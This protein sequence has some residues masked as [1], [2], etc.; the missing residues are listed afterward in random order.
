[1][2]NVCVLMNKSSRGREIVCVCEDLFVILHDTKKE[3]KTEQ[4]TLNHF[5]PFA[6]VCFG[7]IRLFLCKVGA[8]TWRAMTCFSRYLH[9]SLAVDAFSLIRFSFFLLELE[10]L[11]VLFVAIFTRL[12]FFRLKGEKAKFKDRKSIGDKCGKHSVNFSAHHFISVESG[13]FLPSIHHRICAIVPFDHLIVGKASNVFPQPNVLN[14]KSSFEIQTIIYAHSITIK[15]FIR[16]LNEFKWTFVGIQSPET[17][18]RMKN[19]LWNIERFVEHPI[20]WSIT[21]RIKFN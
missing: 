3:L 18:Y 5:S 20:Y 10:G 12:K 8:R 4:F 7:C 1:M 6:A 17:V 2:W 16:A 13:I 11:V 15:L 19:L 9:F 14:S 21:M